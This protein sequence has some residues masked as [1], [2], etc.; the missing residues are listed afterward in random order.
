[1]RRLPLSTIHLHHWCHLDP[2]RERQLVRRIRSRAGKVRYTTQTRK[3]P[4]ERRSRSTLVLQRRPPRRWRPGLCTD[5]KDGA[6]VD[7]VGELELAMRGGQRQSGE[8][9]GPAALS[10][11]DAFPRFRQIFLGKRLKVIANAVRPSADQSLCP[12]AY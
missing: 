9:T 11:A 2:T 12:R 10:Q 7:G 1:M 5:V 4:H 3:V 6:V 8:F